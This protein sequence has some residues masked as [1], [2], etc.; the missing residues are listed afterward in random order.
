MLFG[1]Q[2]HSENGVFVCKHSL[3]ASMRLTQWRRSNSPECE[4]YLWEGKQ[5]TCH[6]F[7]SGCFPVL[8]DLG[9]VSVRG[10]H[11]SVTS[12]TDFRRIYSSAC[13]AKCFTP[14]WA[15]VFSAPQCQSN[16]F[17]ISLLLFSFSFFFLKVD[18]DHNLVSCGTKMSRNIICDLV[19]E[20][21]VLLWSLIKFSG[22][23]IN[24]WND[25]ILNLFH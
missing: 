1:A 14:T 15:S 10:T 22:D 25:T 9:G 2:K 17:T 5:Q 12:V 19:K 3:F 6:S 11:T 8:R 18:Y 20:S 4:S 13:G 23:S 21:G 24:P 16:N 7:H